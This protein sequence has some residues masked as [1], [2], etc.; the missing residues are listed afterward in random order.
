MS[1][2]KLGTPEPKP[3]EEES[4][5]SVEAAVKNNEKDPPKEKPDAGS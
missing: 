1:L 4:K 3:I 5:R 2:R